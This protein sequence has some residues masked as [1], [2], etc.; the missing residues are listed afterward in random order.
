MGLTQEQIA[1]LL[2]PQTAAPQQNG[3][4]RWIDSKAR[5]ASP[6][7]T[8]PTYC[9]VEYVPYCMMHALC[10]LNELVIEI[11]GVKA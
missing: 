2:N 4:L 7:C 11:Q 8:S 10:K 1:N 3:P 9:K 6:G 5:C